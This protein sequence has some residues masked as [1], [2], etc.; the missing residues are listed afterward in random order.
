MSGCASCSA[1]GLS[2]SPPRSNTSTI[3]REVFSSVAAPVPPISQP[4][5]APGCFSPAA[6]ARLRQIHESVDCD[7]DGA[8][9][10]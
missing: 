10:L 5:R 6:V 3:Y 7:S 8:L 4:G 9:R 1:V 2:P